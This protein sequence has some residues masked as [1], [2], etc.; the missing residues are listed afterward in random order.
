M[1]KNYYIIFVLFFWLMACSTSKTFYGTTN[2]NLEATKNV[3]R[4]DLST[5]TGAI[6]LSEFKDL[7]MLNLS[8][9]KRLKK[10]EDVLNSIPNPEQL[11]VLIL[12]HNNLKMLPLSI[13][14]FKQLKQLSLSDNPEL[15]FSHSFKKLAALPLEFLDL[16]H[17]KL[18]NIPKEINQIKTLIDLNLSHNHLSDFSPLSQLP[19]LRSLWLRNNSIEHLST[20]IN[21]IHSLV[22]LYVE[23]NQLKELPN[24]LSGLTSLRVLHL[25]FNEF[26][27][28]P[29]SLQSLPGLM[30]LHIDHCNI[31][32][33]PN[34]FTLKTTPFKG[35]VMNN[36]E[37]SLAQIHHWESVFK[38][39]FLLNF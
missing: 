13:T 35:L 18:E 14:K 19:S 25:S 20:S 15:N 9:I 8:N 11:E 2:Q 17:N 22:N 30:L 39:F 24:N 38:S 27:E 28:L 33:I 21:Q 6:D 32:K 34:S 3:S 10:L 4:L 23:N 37:L 26:K 1:K 12:E 36:N 16:Q 5:Y 7:K 29:E 31:K